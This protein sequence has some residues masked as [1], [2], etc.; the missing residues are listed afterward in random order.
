MYGVESLNKR[1]ISGSRS[2]RQ[3]HH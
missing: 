2:W 1:T 3:L